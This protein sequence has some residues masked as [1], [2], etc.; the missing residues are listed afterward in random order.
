MQRFI[1]LEQ[2][3]LVKYNLNIIEWTILDYIMKANSWAK[4]KERDWRNFFLVHAGKMLEDLP[5]LWIKTNNWILIRIRNLTGAWLLERYDPNSPYYAP[6]EKLRSYY[7]AGSNETNIEV[8]WNEHTTLT[9]WLDNSNINSNINYITLSVD[10]VKRKE[11]SLTKELKS[12]L[13]S[14]EGKTDLQYTSA[15]E[16]IELW[17]SYNSEYKLPKVTINP[18]KDSVMVKSIKRAWADFKTIYSKEEFNTGFK[19]YLDNIKNRKP[20]WKVGSYYNHRF[21]LSVF[22]TQNNWIKKFMSLG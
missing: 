22:L 9:K 10:Q 1:N 16:I 17:N 6:T 18:D 12:L 3:Q 5:S 4:S 2:I 21:T 13:S 11:G 15:I 7:F 14:L 20:D 19:N 8:C